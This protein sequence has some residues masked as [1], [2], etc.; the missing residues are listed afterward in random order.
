MIIRFRAWDIWLGLD[1]EHTFV[2]GSTYEHDFEHLDPD[3]QGEQYLRKRLHRTL[4]ELEKKVTTVDQ[5]AG[6][7]TST[8]NYKPILGQH[9]VHSNMH[10]F[11]GL[12][13]KGLL[14]GKFLADHYANHLTDHTPL[15][16]A[17]A[18]DRFKLS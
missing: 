7:R 2:Q 5:W 10:L 16:P 14:Y 11:G 13:S 4:P 17:V 18:I 1:D 12:G 6:V 9:P 8:P 3:T 15:Y